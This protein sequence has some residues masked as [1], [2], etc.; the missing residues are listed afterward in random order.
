MTQP[1]SIA[2]RRQLFVDDALIDRIGD[3]V[4]LHLHRPVPREVAAVEAS[5][6]G[7]VLREHFERLSGRAR[8]SKGVRKTA[9][10]EDP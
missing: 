5:W 2:D 6:T 7:R 10:T 4:R 9:R 8:E 1:K 3:D